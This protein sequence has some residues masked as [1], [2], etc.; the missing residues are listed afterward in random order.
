MRQIRLPVI[1]ILML[2]LLLS[3]LVLVAHETAMA[4]VVSSG[5]SAKVT[6]NLAS[7]GEGERD[8]AGATTD[9][10]TLGNYAYTGT[11][12]NPCGGDPDGGV[13]IWDVNN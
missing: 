9:V 7:F 10:W 4:D 1:M 3:L 2:S 6:K 5:P 11:S 12:N 13:W 8:V